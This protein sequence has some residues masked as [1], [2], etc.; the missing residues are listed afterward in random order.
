MFNK[1]SYGI[2]YSISIDIFIPCKEPHEPGPG[3]ALS[4]YDSHYFC[5]P[6]RMLRILIMF[7]V[8]SFPFGC[9]GGEIVYINMWLETTSGIGPGSDRGVR[10]YCSFPRSGFFSF[11]GLMR[12]IIALCVW[13]LALGLDQTFAYRGNL[14]P[15]CPRAPLRRCQAVIADPK[16][17]ENHLCS[18]T[19]LHFL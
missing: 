13:V 11:S 12:F 4:S 3:S 10:F 16:A 8:I 17:C 2:L 18:R 19:P 5:I 14:P 9:N 15:S 7:A 1:T 6:W